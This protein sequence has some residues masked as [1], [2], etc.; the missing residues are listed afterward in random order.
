MPHRM[1]RHLQDGDIVEDVY[2]AGS[3]ALRINRQGHPYLQVELRDRSGS[4]IARMWNANEQIFQAFREGEC[5]FVRGKAQMFQGSIQIILNEIRPATTDQWDPSDFLPQSEID[6][7]VLWNRLRQLL[8]VK[9]PHLRALV[10]MF[11]QDE[12]LMQCFVRAP[13]GSRLH[14][15]Y[16]GGLLEHVVHMLEIAHRIF[17]GNNSLYPEVNTDLVLAGI[18]LHDIGKVRELAYATHF[19]YTDEGQLLGHLV[20]GIE[21]LHDKVGEVEKLLGEPF[22]QELLLRL[23]H[24]IISHH[25]DLESGSPRVPMT[26]EAMVVYLIDQLDSRL[27]M[28]L[29]EL[30]EDRYPDRAW[31]DF[32][33]FLERR[34]FRGQTNAQHVTTSPSMDID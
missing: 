21:I 16:L 12:T 27:H 13:A 4:M 11:L 33:P 2:L 9:N 31:T 22:P 3:K 32:H 19:A 26:P 30:R 28:I 15:P 1:L 14:H 8:Q 5:V 18:F 7:S 6:S 25:G 34:L 20:I 17:G 23:K 24:I 10:N 29:R